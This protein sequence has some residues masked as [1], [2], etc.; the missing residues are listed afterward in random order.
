VSIIASL[1]D[2]EPRATKGASAHP[3]D[4]VLADIF[5]S[6]ADTIS[7]I[8]VNARTS[9]QV[10]AF[11]AA[12]RSI[13]EDVGKLPFNLYRRLGR[14]GR[15]R[16][17]QHP[18]WS[19]MHDD[20][21]PEMSSMTLRETM[22]G[23]TLT[24]GNGYAQIMRAANGRAGE[25]WPLPT[26]AVTL[27]RTRDNKLVY[28]FHPNDRLQTTT[29]LPAEDVFHVRGVGGDGIQG[30]SVLKLARESIGLTLAAEYFGAGF[31][32]NDA[33][34]GGVL[35]HPE[36]LEPDARKNLKESWTEAHAGATNSRRLAVLE[37]GMEWQQIGIPADD[38][39][40]LETREFQVTDIARWF[41]M[42]PHKLQQLLRATFSNIEH[43]S[44]EY[45]TDT[46][47][48]WLR[49]WEHEANRKLLGPAERGDLFFEHLVEALLRG[50]SK[51]RSEFYRQMFGIG[52]MSRN[53]IR[54][55]ENLNPIDGGD[56]LMVP[57]NM[58]PVGE[59]G[60]PISPERPD[61]SS[62]T[63]VPGPNRDLVGQ[64]AQAHI[65]A[66]AEALQRAMRFEADKVKRAAKRGEDM[67]AWCEKF[68][69]EIQSYMRAA[70]GPP[71]DT[72]ADSLA[73]VFRGR[74]LADDERAKLV[75]WL[76]S[77]VQRELR[78]SRSR[79]GTVVNAG[80][81]FNGWQERAREVSAAWVG[82]L[83]QFVEE[84]S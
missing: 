66:I 75:D 57:L 28:L 46:L 51:A 19:L 38:A 81:A 27:D 59:D 12:V 60:V 23:W 76:A 54:Q 34:P 52:A 36:K 48:P 58:G 25:L 32:G 69:P 70:V 37:E 55:R 64:M 10:S 62:E 31:F 14:G 77:A 80:A 67:Q 26:N 35:K 21:N 50:D 20:P 49:R 41:R 18:L 56:T 65:D 47:M 68:Y 9:M 8:S 42:P 84:Y 13:A 11:Y 79:I 5:G 24:W 1:L 43:Q 74:S 78:E 22:M 61:Q 30:W 82:G 3:R 63:D 44:I 53:E 39:Q 4:P 7:G 45:V 71:V 17:Q 15:E 83:V 16:M 6:A 73:L 40:F 2:T 33:S 72:A 29:V